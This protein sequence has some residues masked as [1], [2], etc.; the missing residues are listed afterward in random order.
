[1]YERYYII[2][3]SFQIFSE[4]VY[5]KNALIYFVLKKTGH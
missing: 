5:I 3:S 2:T 1:M 4:T